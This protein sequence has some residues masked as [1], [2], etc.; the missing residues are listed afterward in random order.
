MSGDVSDAG[1][2][3]GMALAAA[4]GQEQ[5]RKALGEPEWGEE[6]EPYAGLPQGTDSSG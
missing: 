4:L 6:A 2:A 5:E 3:F 1:V